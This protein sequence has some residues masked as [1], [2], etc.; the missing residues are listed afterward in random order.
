L[1]TSILITGI[2]SLSVLFSSPQGQSDIPRYDH[3]VVVIE[4]NHA[5]NELIGSP[6]AP[7][8]NELAK[9]GTLFTDSH[10]IGHPSQP[11]YLA[12]FSGS[13]QRVTGDGC[14]LKST[15]FKTP[16]LGAALLHKGLTFKGY[17][18]TMPAVG[19]LGC[20]S[21]SSSVTVGH[22]Y[23][24]KHTPWVNWLGTGP[25][26]IP[27]SLSM[28]MTEFPKNFKKLPTISFVVPNMDNDMH[29]IG[30]AGNAAAISRG[31]QWLK[32]NI[33]DYAKWAK[34]HNSLLIVTFDEDD[35]DSKNGNRI[36]TIF[37]G[38]KVNTMKYS[39]S[40]NHYYVLHTLEVMY[41]LPSD[42]D[43]SAAPISGIWEK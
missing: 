3:V 29:N 16:N 32:K 13:T 19:F 26:C 4:E 1:K 15:P 25:N 18:E 28:P 30:M 27:D 17:A 31:D 8:I 23:A 7:Y 38:D 14:L 42:D 12:L 35:Y 40:I 33:S 9:D 2:V 24:R 39:K 11:N 37:Y 34:K 20:T 41:G 22:L 21:R 10:G 36:A 43:V 5:Y 6:N